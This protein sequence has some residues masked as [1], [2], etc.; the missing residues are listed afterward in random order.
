MSGA[1]RGNDRGDKNMG[2]GAPAS[3][4]GARDDQIMCIKWGPGKTKSLAPEGP[5]K[6]I[7]GHDLA[8][9]QL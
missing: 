6:M 7:Y 2:P 5:R 8:I 9:F 1:Q 4:R 3:P